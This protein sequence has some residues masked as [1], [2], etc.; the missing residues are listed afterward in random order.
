MRKLRRQIS[1]LFSLWSGSST[2]V[3]KS[4]HWEFPKCHVIIQAFFPWTTSLNTW[5]LASGRAKDSNSFASPS[6]TFIEYIVLLKGMRP[7]NI[8]P[9]RKWNLCT[10]WT[11]IFFFLIEHHQ[12][13]YKSNLNLVD[14]DCLIWCFVMLNLPWSNL[15][16]YDF[17][18]SYLIV[19]EDWKISLNQKFTP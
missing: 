7:N 15:S 13:Y 1:V 14:N 4:H 6:I 17:K 11:S 5:P 10:W 16:T 19:Y 3:S 8:Y 2:Y 18:C 12:C 9:Q